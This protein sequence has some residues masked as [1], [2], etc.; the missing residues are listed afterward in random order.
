MMRS[1]LNQLGE[2][3]VPQGPPEF[4]RQLHDRIN[5]RLLS[6]HLV[7]VV[8]R[9]LPFAC[10]HFFVTLFGAVKFSLTGRY[11]KGDD[12]AE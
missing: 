11:P 10:F 4:R 7:E 12:H 8:V 5:A 2:Q 6:L 3:P 9:L 1:V